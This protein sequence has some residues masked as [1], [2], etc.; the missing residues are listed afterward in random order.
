M[1]PWLLERLVDPVN[2]M[3][4]RR[5]GQ[6]LIAQD[7]ARYPVI[8]G[9]PVLLR[10]DTAPTHRTALRSLRLAQW[11]QPET[12]DLVTALNLPDAVKADIRSD[13]AAGD[14]PVH[15][16]IR[17]LI[18]LTNGLAFRTVRAGTIPI[19]QFPRQGA[20][21]WLLDIGCAWGRWSI[22][23]QRAGFRPV[24]IDTA[25]GPL[26]AARRLALEH[27]APIDF[28]CADARFL[29]FRDHA[30]DRVF[31]YS[32]L[33][34]F[35]DDDCAAALAEIARVL[36]AGGS[37]LVQMANR[38][39]IRSL[40][41]QLRRGLREPVR[42]EVR[43]RSLARLRELFAAIGP[44]TIS[45]DCFFGLGLQASDIAHMRL[46]GRLATRASEFLKLA[47]RRVPVLLAVADSV[48]CESAASRVSAP[49][50]PPPRPA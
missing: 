2:R 41:H 34:H 46:A 11:S 3:P 28:V 27:G 13:I 40:W 44:T 30:F 18:P 9:V 21:E 22:A 26:M 49:A 14:N 43:Y 38:A 36:A 37:S 48:F 20:G 7:G 31:S 50:A 47:Q 12:I 8:D 45:V 16:A 1:H 24:G 32:T 17:R 42:F 29:P 10:A 5:D 6:R 19:P 15:A 25:L 39:G 33:Q 35:A 4:M 23:A